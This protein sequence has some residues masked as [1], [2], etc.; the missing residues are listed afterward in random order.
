MAQAHLGHPITTPQAVLRTL[1]N[2]LVHYCHKLVKFFAQ[3][4]EN[5]AQY[6]REPE[7]F[8]ER[9]RKLQGAQSLETMESV[10][11]VLINQVQSITHFSKYE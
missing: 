6:L 9:T 1:F 7:K 8:V 11:A 3:A 10:K 5:A 4:Q 2:A